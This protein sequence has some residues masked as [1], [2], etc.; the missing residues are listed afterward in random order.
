LD[1]TDASI[2]III[3]AAMEFE[4]TLHETLASGLGG[5]VTDQVLR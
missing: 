5:E 1:A 3:Q 2:I 4:R